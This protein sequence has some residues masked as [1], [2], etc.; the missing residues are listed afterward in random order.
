MPKVEHTRLIVKRYRT[1]PGSLDLLADSIQRDGLE[2]PILVSSNWT[3]LSGERR[4]GALRKLG[5]I[6]IPVEVVD[7]LEDLAL[8]MLLE[9]DGSRRW[10]M[11]PSEV[12][13]QMD[14]ILTAGLIP[15]KTNTARKG[16][17]IELLRP[18]Y[19][20]AEQWMSK[21]LL[22]Y[23][24][25]HRGRD[26]EDRTLAHSALN[27]IDAGGGVVPVARELVAHLNKKYPG[28][29]RWWYGYLDVGEDIVPAASKMTVGQQ[30]AALN[31]VMPMIAGVSSTLRMVGRLHPDLPKVESLAWAAQ[32]KAL[33]VALR[34]LEQDLRGAAYSESGE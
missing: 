11:H 12:A 29:T 28:V 4:L 15:P 27:S 7:S 30:L 33:R 14:T 24:T 5:A 34:H 21:L 31:R 8:R 20:R 32:A 3:V 2:T 1:S 10:S 22:I 17:E 6:E 26:E 18:V 13:A 23:R 25:A 16:S 9:K 19:D